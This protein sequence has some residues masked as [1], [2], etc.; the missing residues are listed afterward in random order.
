ME[1]T[2]PLGSLIEYIHGSLSG[3]NAAVSSIRVN[4]MELTLESETALAAVPL[5]DIQSVDVCFTTPREL[6]EETLDIL[7]PYSERM[8]T[9]CGHAANDETVFGKLLD[10]LHVFSESIG[11]I[12][13]TLRIGYLP[14]VGLLEAELLSIL[15]DLL[16]A[17]KTGD[18]EYIAQ[19]LGQ[20]L[21]AVLAD[22]RREGFAALRKA[23]DS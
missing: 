9:L 10:G 4:G 21:P 17:R 23:R 3:K 13:S 16:E 7:A 8:E 18:K 14:R 1:E 19:L 12:K 15:S 5:S 20:H 11:V 22:W 2:R 6:A